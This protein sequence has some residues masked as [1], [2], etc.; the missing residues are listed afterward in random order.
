MS[1]SLLTFALLGWALLLADAGP[2]P[3]GSDGLAPDSQ[4]TA[5]G[6]P[7]D[8]ADDP[9]EALTAAADG[10]PSTPA[11]RLLPRP[12][13]GIAFDR[14]LHSDHPARAPPEPRSA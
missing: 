5:P 12:L 9:P 14:R 11:P 2:G 8:P 7:G 4:S 13:A 3:D 1:R 10:A 6:V